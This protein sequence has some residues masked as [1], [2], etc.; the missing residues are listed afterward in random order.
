MISIKTFII[1]LNESL[2]IGLEKLFS[3]IH[4]SYEQAEG[5]DLTDLHGGMLNVECCVSVSGTWDQ[6]LCNMC[7]LLSALLCLLPA[8][9]RYH[10]H[11]GQRS[12]ASVHHHLNMNHNHSKHFHIANFDL[13]IT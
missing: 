13:K 12:S 9:V 8:S 2:A 4:D 7:L 5:C 10:L 11:W 1:N 6:V 3:V